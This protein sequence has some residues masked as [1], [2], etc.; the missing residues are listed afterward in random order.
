MWW[1]RAIARVVANDGSHGTGFLISKSGLLLTAFHVVGNLAASR[2]DKTPVYLGAGPGPL[3]FQVTIDGVESRASVHGTCVDFDADWIVLQ[4]DVTKVAGIEPIPLAKFDPDGDTRFTTYG[5]PISRDEVNGGTFYGE[6]LRW[7]REPSEVDCKNLLA[8]PKKGGEDVGGI[9]GAPLIVDGRAVGIIIQAF[10]DLTSGGVV[11]TNLYVRPIDGV[12]AKLGQV[13]WDDGAP[14]EFQEVVAAKLPDDAERLR[15]ASAVLGMKGVASRKAIARGLLRSS[16]STAGRVL[17]PLGIA[18]R[19]ALTILELI[20]AMR[21]HEDAV[22][23]VRKPL[24]VFGPLEIQPPP[25][26]FRIYKWHVQRAYQP[27]PAA[28]DGR[29]IVVLTLASSAAEA[30]GSAVKVV[31]DRVRSFLVGKRKLGKL[32]VDNALSET[33]TNVSAEHKVWL[34]LRGGWSPV[35]IA[36]LR[37]RPNLVLVL[38]AA[39]DT[40]RD[41]LDNLPDVTAVSPFL[42]G[43]EQMDLLVGFETASGDLSI[44]EQPEAEP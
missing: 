9:S 28:I 24:P 43:P 22:A 7:D 3:T 4:C 42:T 34:V 10:A 31:I 29:R 27:I 41:T 1:T 11:T 44:E 21:L 33:P 36:D 35:L 5:Y 8:D 26:G 12:A 30:A 16:L 15:E 20:A 19:D 17:L 18:E 6:V 37:K 40:D 32:V 39:G 23:T 25:S 38:A 2:R 14:V 13:S